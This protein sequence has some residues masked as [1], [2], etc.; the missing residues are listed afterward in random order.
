MILRPT[1]SR[2]LDIVANHDNGDIRS[3]RSLNR[4]GNAFVVPCGITQ[5]HV[6]FEPARLLARRDLAPFCVIHF[7]P[8]P[9]L[10]FDSL[11]NTYSARW[12]TVVFAKLNVPGVWTNHSYGTDLSPVERQQIVFVFQQ[13]DGFARRPQREQAAFLCLA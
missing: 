2:S 1:L 6:I 11:K 13:R 12:S 3:L 8:G 9:D 10:V 7:D 4:F 5:P